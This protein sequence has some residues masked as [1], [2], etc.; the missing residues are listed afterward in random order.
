M[1][2]AS[3]RGRLSYS[4][5]ETLLSTWE[6]ARLAPGDI[7]LTTREAGY[8]GFVLFNNLPI[9][10]GEVIVFPDSFGVRITDTDF[11]PRFQVDPGQRDSLGE[12]LPGMVELGGFETD[13]RSWA[14]TGSPCFLNLGS[15]VDGDHN[16]VLRWAGFDL[17]R[18][19]VVVVGEV[20]GLRITERLVEWPQPT[21]VLQTGSLADRPTK[22]RAKDYDFRRPDRFSWTQIRRF[23]EIHRLFQ[24]HLEGSF[25]LYAQLL[26]GRSEAM[27]VDQCT[28][29]EA[30]EELGR[31]GLEA[32]VTW[33]H[34]GP[35]RGRR[36]EAPA[37]SMTLLEAP[38]CPRPLTSD[39]RR[40]LEAITSP[41][42]LLAQRPVFVHYRADLH[43][44]VGPVMADCLRNGW[45][46]FLDFPL[47]TKSEVSASSP[48]LEDYEMVLLVLVR[49]DSSESPL[50]AFVYPFVTVEPYVGLLGSS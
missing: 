9:G 19:V 39:A 44:T 30:R 4:V 36:T 28:L 8:P 3:L 11:R 42:S 26:D 2:P 45:K 31:L 47:D 18:G 16:A 46:K 34:E 6:A 41:H 43:A 20:M 38:D 29:K 37:V 21:R 10:L 23:T 24:R 1:E 7:V 5:G 22:E 48:L 50:L 12:V 27:V 49:R 35:R 32:S 13:L 25:P 14:G 40:S 33:E 15:P 17:A